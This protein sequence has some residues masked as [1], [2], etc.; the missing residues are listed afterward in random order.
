M[1]RRLTLG[2]VAVTLALG[3]VAAGCS[4]PP[5]P[6]PAPEPEVITETPTAEPVDK[7]AVPDPQVEEVWPLTGVPGQAADRPVLSVKI[8]NSVNA[9]PQTGLNGADIVWEQMIEHGET[10]LVAMFHS[11]VPGVVGPIR[12]LRPM[13]IPIVTPVGGLI[14]FSGGQ[15]PFVQAAQR[16]PLQVLSHD[17]GSGGFYRSS[18][19]FAPH[20]VYGRTRDFLDQASS[21]QGPAQVFSYAPKTEWSSAALDGNRT[22]AIRLE[23]PNTQPG[24]VW[25]SNSQRWLRRESGADAVTTDAGR[26]RAVNVVV[27]RVQVRNTEFRDPAGAPVPETQVVGSGDAVVASRGRT[28]RGTWSKED[29]ASPVVFT[30][31]DGE[32]ILLAPGNT[33]VELVPESGGSVAL[34]S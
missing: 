29:A 27:M 10:R 17:S 28:I 32:E 15:H 5:P 31:G 14:A 7:Q 16:S 30:D 33:W 9:R 13:D 19:R 8:E 11:D 20:N 18:D 4:E 34:R 6:P 12:S 22:S 23:F 24:W 1:I 3:L 25:S 21:P 2:G 26:I